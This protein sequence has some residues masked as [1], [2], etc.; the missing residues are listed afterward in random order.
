MMTNPIDIFR[1]NLNRV[2]AIHQLYIGITAKLTSIVDA[3]DLLRAE[4]VLILSA[5][6]QFIH[7]TARRGMMET[8]RGERPPTQAFV[9]FQVPLSVVRQIQFDSVVIEGQ[10]EAA[11]LERHSYL[12]FQHPDKI[13]DAIRLV[14]E[15]QLWA[16][17]AN[18]MNEQAS[19]V[20][21]TLKL[22][23]DRRNKIAHE[24]DID[25]SYPGQRWPIG[26]EDAEEALEFVERVGDAIH[27]VL[28]QERVND[29]DKKSVSKL[30]ME[31][32]RD[33][34]VSSGDETAGD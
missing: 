23:V 6:D 21:T 10:L 33:H 11:I 24:A 16:S 7:E 34:F 32:H 20:K 12:S 30:G 26:R 1:E 13:A 3:S 5:L 8:W 22:L 27:G 15:I 14:S 28:A 29:I 17:V 4:I 31:N 9:K 18:I 25:P 19:F 2:R